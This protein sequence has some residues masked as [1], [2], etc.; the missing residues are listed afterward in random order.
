MKYVRAQGHRLVVYVVD[1]IIV[2]ADREQMKELCESVVD[3]LQK[4]GFVIN[5][6][7]KQVVEWL[8]FRVDLEYGKISI[9]H[10]KTMAACQSIGNLL[11]NPALPHL[12]KS[13]ASLVGKL[14]S[15]S[16]AVG[17]IARLRTIELCT[18]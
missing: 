11:L 15:F 8:G 18:E 1:D 3:T 17:P 13:I 9:L 16:L 10:E 7:T 6:S 14:I 12:A 5:M 2:G 4:A